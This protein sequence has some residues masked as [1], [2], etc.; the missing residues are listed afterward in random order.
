MA[1]LRKFIVLITGTFF[2]I[3]YLPL[4]PGTFGSLAGLGLFYLVKDSMPIYFLFTVALIILGF[5]VS[6]EAEEILNKKDARPIVIDEVCGM[7]LSLLFIPY[8]IKLTIIAFFVFRL[9][10]TLK[11]FPSCALERLKGSAGVMSDDIIAGIYT[12]IILQ[13]VVRLASF[14]T[15]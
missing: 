10:D 3:G 5:L 1:G 6:G 11:P 13:V 12:N 2:Y 15:S 7:L 4:I 9:L 8:D 14:R